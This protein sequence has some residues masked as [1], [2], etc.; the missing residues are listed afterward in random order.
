MAMATISYLALVCYMT[1]TTLVPATLSLA[2]E[3]NVSLSKAVYLGSTP[4]ALYGVAPWVWSPMSHFLGRRPVLLI[5]NIIAMAGTVITSTAENY[6]VCMAGRVILGIGGSSF[7]TLGP[8]CIDEIF[9]NH[10]KG[11]KIGIS[12]LAIVFSTFLGGIIGG[13]IMHNPSLGWRGTQWIPLILMGTGFVGQVFFLPETMYDREAVA[14]EVC[15]Q[16]ARRRSTL[17]SQYGVSMPKRSGAPQHGF[18]FVAT[19]PLTLLRYPVVLLSSFWFGIVYTMIVG[20]FSEIPLIF[21][22][23]FGFTQLDVGLASIAGLI[24]AVLGEALAGP[25]INTFAKRGLRNGKH[26]QP[27]RTLNAI[28]PSLIAVPG[29]LIMFGTSIQ[30][31][32]SWVTPLVGMGI[33]TFGIEVGMTVVQT[34]IL[35]CY[36]KQGAEVN[37]IFNLFRNVMTYVSPFFVEPMI[38]K[39]GTSAPYCLFAG[40]TV[41]FFPF[42]M[43]ILMWRGERI[44]E[45]SGMPN[46][47]KE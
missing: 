8:A 38:A 34:Y 45:K 33:Y 26:W 47:G 12:T 24:G 16:T 21:E 6:G 10:E 29:G 15:Q 40:L 27:E 31:G 30:F 43:G 5:S 42:T 44:R 18:W 36:T 13:A 11:T 41:F 25:S 3:F 23:Q 46:W 37:L 39:L 4:V 2:T 14:A 35:E 19:R 28:W 17:W 32:R 7:W 20:V 22:P 1:V 9:F